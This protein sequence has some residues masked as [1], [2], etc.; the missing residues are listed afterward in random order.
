[1]EL[2]GIHP[3]GYSSKGVIQIRQRMSGAVVMDWGL[4]KGLSK[5][6]FEQ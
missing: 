1:M 6:I 4:R 2:G 3:E 5:K